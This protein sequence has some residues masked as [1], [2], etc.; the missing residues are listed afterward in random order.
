MEGLNAALLVDEAIRHPAK[1][2]HIVSILY[3]DDMTRRFAAAKALGEIARREPELMKQRW[4]R[5]FRLFDDTMS[6]WGAAEAL[7][8]IARNMPQQNRT[9]IVHF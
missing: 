9:K 4:E 3:D 7:G 5:I 8:E 1:I 2:R 6:C